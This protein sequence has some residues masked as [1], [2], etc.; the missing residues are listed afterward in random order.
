MGG[1]ILIICR[2]I[3]QNIFHGE[4]D[5]VELESLEKSNLRFCIV[6]HTKFTTVHFLN[7]ASEKQ[8]G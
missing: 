2:H 6:E 7:K 3:P 4:I 8:Q 1:I 5:G